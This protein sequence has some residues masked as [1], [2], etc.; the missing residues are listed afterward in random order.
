MADWVL[1]VAP[2][3][4]VG[5]NHGARRSGRV[6]IGIRAA[7]RGFHDEVLPRMSRHEVGREWMRLKLEAKALR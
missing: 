6:E 7:T 2:I 5:E 3:D 1:G 4:F